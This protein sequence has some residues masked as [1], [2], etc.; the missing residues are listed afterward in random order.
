VLAHSEESAR[1]QSGQMVQAIVLVKDF[2][3]T[4]LVLQRR[5]STTLPPLTARRASSATVWTKRAVSAPAATSA[6]GAQTFLLCGILEK[7][8]MKIKS[9]WEFQKILEE[10]PRKHGSSLYFRGHS[11]SKYT[12]EPSLF[13]RNRY[14]KNEHLMFKEMLKE[15][16]AHFSEDRTTLEKLVK[17]QH[18]GLPTRLLDITKNP[19]VAL[20]FACVTHEDKTASKNDGEVVVLSLDGRLMKYND[21]DTAMILS[22]LCKLKPSEKKF[23]TS[24]SIEKFNETENVGKL[25]WEIK[26]EKAIFYDIINPK[27]INSIIPVKVAKNNERIQI[28]DGLFLLYGV[29]KDGNKLLVPSDW[30]VKTKTNECVLIDAESKGKI[31]DQLQEINISKKTLFPDLENTANFIKRNYA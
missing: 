1:Q 27:H 19:L 6:A 17:M 13:R 11:D 12:L 29:G 5:R 31:R 24:L 18:F 3:G 9:L 15:R 10:L 14:L 8:F 16:P 2:V 22:N 21:S 28:Q 7:S 23:D 26:R 25:L 4:T 20:Y 30:I